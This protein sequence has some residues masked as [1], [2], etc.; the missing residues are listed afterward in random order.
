MQHRRHV[1]A[2]AT[3]AHDDQN[4]PPRLGTTEVPFNE[5]WMERGK[6]SALILK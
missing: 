5:R 6:A 4:T 3:A 1:I 2:I